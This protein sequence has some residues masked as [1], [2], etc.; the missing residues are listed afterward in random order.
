MF[1]FVKDGDR[2][3]MYS[4]RRRKKKAFHYLIHTAQ[5]NV[6]YYNCEDNNLDDMI[7]KTYGEKQPIHSDEQILI[8]FITTSQLSSFLF[9]KINKALP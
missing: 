7:R 5:S 1:I 9:K 4:K 3:L 8:V 6:K 2:F